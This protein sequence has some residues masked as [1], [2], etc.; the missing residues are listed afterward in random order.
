MSGF[1]LQNEPITPTPAGFID[2]RFLTGADGS[3]IVPSFNFNPV[4]HPSFPSLASLTVGTAFSLDLLGGLFLVDPGSPTSEVGF[5]VVSGTDPRKAGWT[6]V[7]GVLSN[8]C[9]VVNSGV[10]QLVALRNGISILSPAISYS[11]GVPAGLDTV[12]PSI[13]TGIVATP[14]TT[15]G[16]VQIVF[17]PPCDVA[18]PGVNAGGSAHVDLY[19]SGVKTSP[20]TPIAVPSNA[21][22]APTTVNLGAA[23]I[24]PSVSQSGKLWTISAAGTGIASTTSEQAGLVDFGVVSGVQQVIARL[25]NYTAGTATTALMGVIIHDTAVAGGRF[26]AVGLGPSDGTT[27]LYYIVRTTIGGTSTTAVTQLKDVNGHTITGPVYVKLARATSGA[28]KFSYSLDQ[29]AWIDV[30]TTTVAM[31][32]SPHYGLFLTSASA[33]TTVTGVVDEVAITNG[34]QITAVLTTSTAVPF[35]LIAVDRDNN[36]SLPSV[37]VVGTPSTNPNNSG[38]VLFIS[39]YGFHADNYFYNTGVEKANLAA[40]ITA[41]SGNNQI[42][43][44][45]LYLTWGECEGPTQ[46]DYS[47]MDSIF[48]DLL[49]KLRAMSQKCYLI[50][51]HN[52]PRTFDG[53]NS[54]NT[55]P[56]YALNNGWVVKITSNFNGYVV[57]WQNPAT[58]TAYTN[59]LKYCADKYSSDPLFFA[60]STQDESDMVTN[61]AGL[62]TD[63]QWYSVYKQMQL[64]IKAH[65]P[66]KF[67]WVRGNWMPPGGALEISRFSDLLTTLNAAYPGG[68]CYG[69]PDY[70]QRNTT[71]QQVFRGE[72]GTTGDLRGKYMWIAH[73]EET[74]LGGDPNP[75]LLWTPQSQISQAIA[76]TGTG[77]SAGGW[78]HIW[79]GN[80]TNSVWHTGE[81][82]G[83]SA[84]LWSVGTPNQVGAIN[85]SAKPLNPPPSVGSYIQG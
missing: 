62:V 29:T 60:M 59:M 54:T 82:A 77:A 38:T 18:P 69:G 20:P 4:A 56:Q 11:I 6:V 55:F 32:T 39:G 81:V 65:L 17:D 64:D 22:A 21:L 85:A 8:P 13:P 61:Q 10:F 80:Y 28:T 14:G 50:V 47:K 40:G 72:V 34:T 36:A 5:H 12:A 42:I 75:G 46:G 66:N 23:A 16:T 7:S 33:T 49:P 15:V 48:S 73:V 79:I 37:S 52:G 83:T 25:N 84:Y 9:T 58:V 27:G 43:V 68:Y 2:S 45:E 31:G 67:V 44:V 19:I 63:T 35:T 26:A 76:H 41:N 51:N 78:A 24:V 30:N 74:S 1:G 71:F 57:T 53:S 70:I 3:N